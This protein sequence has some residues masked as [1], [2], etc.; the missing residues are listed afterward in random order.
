MKCCLDR[1]QR[2]PPQCSGFPA[3]AGMPIACWLLHA[4]KGSQRAGHQQGAHSLWRTD[5]VSSGWFQSLHRHTLHPLYTQLAKDNTATVLDTG[6][7]WAAAFLRFFASAAL[8]L[9]ASPVLLF[10]APPFVPTF[11]AGSLIP[12]LCMELWLPHQSPE[13]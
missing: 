7:P 12:S 13:N 10:P 11:F 2:L 4:T 1:A 6:A 3:C 8:F 5:H 9:P